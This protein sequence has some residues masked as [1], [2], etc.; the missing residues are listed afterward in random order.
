MKS[1]VPHT[2]I[3]IG[4]ATGAVVGIIANVL[5]VDPGPPA[6]PAAW[7]AWLIRNITEPVG[8]VF[9]NLLIMTVIPLVFASLAVGVAR[10]GD[11][12]KLGRMGAK[13]FGFFLVTS[14][15]AAVIGLLLVN[16]V[17]PGKTVS[18]D[19]VTQLREAYGKSAEQKAVPAEFGVQT[20]V[21]MVPRNPIQAAAEMNMLG[22]IIFALLVGVGLTYIPAE[23]ARALI[24]VLEGIG[25]LM[26]FIISVAMR[27]APVGVF[28]LI[29]SNTAQFG[30]GL[31]TSLGLYA[32]V[33]MIGL[34]LQMFG[35]FPLL[36]QLAAH[37][38]P[39]Q[40]FRQIRGVMLTAFSTSSSNATLPTS[41]R[42]A[43]EDLGI[44]KPVA[45][46]VLPLG[47]TMNMN[48]TALFEGVTVLFLAQVAGLE[49]SLGQQVLVVM[50]SVLTAIGAAG[51]PGGSIP[52]IAM[53]LVSVNVPPD[54]LFLILGVDRVLDMF[55]TTV[56]VVGD[57]TAVMVINRFEEA[58]ELLAP[59]PTSVPVVLNGTAVPTEP[60]STT[61]SE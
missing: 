4:L 7:L 49:L 20:F 24:P 3:L 15:S 31:L 50:L 30:F 45:G 46:F 42:V 33:V 52:L 5:F 56:N 54:L 48:G 57:L 35:V 2:S 47:A 14:V 25:D 26:V 28:C 59:A 22:I 13:T 10:L 51:V 1:S 34:G 53:V 41:I 8:R 29:F 44:P 9:L 6:L 19:T 27:L 60:T 61:K 36:L 55:R 17:E 18:E 37:T 23:R 21:N 43:Q 38:N 58:T 16:L 39:W 32:L 11:M 40:F 12:S